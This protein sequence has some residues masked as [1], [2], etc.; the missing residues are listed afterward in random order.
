MKAEV[1]FDPESLKSDEER[2]AEIDQ[3]LA[4]GWQF[5][6]NFFDK[7]QTYRLVISKKDEE[8]IFRTTRPYPKIVDAAGRIKNIP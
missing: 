8:R 6:G 7:D 1:P 2:F 5:K 3:L 4:E